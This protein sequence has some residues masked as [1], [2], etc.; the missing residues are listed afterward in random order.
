MAPAWD[1]GRDKYLLMRLFL[2]SEATIT[3]AQADDLASEMD[4][5][6]R[7]LRSVLLLST[8]FK[9]RRIESIIAFYLHFY[10]SFDIY[11]LSPTFLP[12]FYTI[13]SS[14]DSQS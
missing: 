6:P 11:F 4:V 5:H 1:D 8:L 14:R 10:P 7:T 3:T 13:A 2:G 9:F 12:S